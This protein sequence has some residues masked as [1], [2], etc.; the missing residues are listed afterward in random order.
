MLV[1]IV[2]LSIQDDCISEFLQNFESQKQHIRHFEGCRFLELYNDKHNKNIF[3]TYS[4]W[5]HED[6][7][8]T[9]RHSDLFKGIWAVTKPMFNAKP[10]AW[11]VDKLESLT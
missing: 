11:S 10:E 3:F 9:Y 4:Y 6:A 7:L 5:D 2:K 1:R 8:N